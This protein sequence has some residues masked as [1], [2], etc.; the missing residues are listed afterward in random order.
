[1]GHIRSSKMVLPVCRLYQIDLNQQNF[2]RDV[3]IL[4]KIN[5]VIMPKFYVAPKY[6]AELVL[7]SPAFLGKK[8]Q[9]KSGKVKKKRVHPDFSRLASIILKDRVGLSRPLPKF[10]INQ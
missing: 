7:F 2:H 6:S 1:M 3:T 4:D 9:E 10:R 8:S 5:V